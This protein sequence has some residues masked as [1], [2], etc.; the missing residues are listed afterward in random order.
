M[1][2]TLLSFLISLFGLHFNISHKL[3]STYKNTDKLSVNTMSN[4]C[5]NQFK[6]YIKK[7]SENE[8]KQIKN[9]KFPLKFKY[10]KEM[11]DEN[12]SEDSISKITYKF[13][14]FTKDEQA[15]KRKVDA[16]KIEIE[17]LDQ[18]NFIYKR[19]GIDNGIY[20]CYKFMNKEGNWILTEIFDQS[21]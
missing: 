7:F 13:L 17:Q 1:Q 10:Y 6:L 3:P 9:V 21:S 12:Y 15:K 16:F 5:L 4:D 11:T 8:Q 18:C 20:I 14:N 2:L 19:I